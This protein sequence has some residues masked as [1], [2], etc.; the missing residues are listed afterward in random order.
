MHCHGQPLHCNF[1]APAKWLAFLILCSLCAFTVHAHQVPSMTLET[2]FSEDDSA[3]FS[4]NL[5]PRC[6][7]AEVPTTLPPVPA[8]WWRDQSEADKTKTSQD[9]NSFLQKAM[10]LQLGGKPIDLPAFTFTPMDAAT[11]QEFTAESKEVHLLGKLTLK[12]PAEADSF[13]VD[14][15]MSATVPL[16]LLNSLTTKPAGRPQLLFPGETSRPFKLPIAAPPPTPAP[17]PPAE[18]TPA[19]TAP[20]LWIGIGGIVLF[21]AITILSKRRA[22]KPAN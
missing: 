3:A 14:Y 22:P 10:R 8:E 7:L 17:E 18:T 11:N 1:S 15:T 6:F 16:V 9:A 4:I 20:W 19:K 5:D 12:V 13:V 21:A 2:A